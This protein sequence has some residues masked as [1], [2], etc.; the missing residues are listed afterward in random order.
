[1]SNSL[2]ILVRYCQPNVLFTELRVPF[3]LLKIQIEVFAAYDTCL[4]SKGAALLLRLILL[5]G[6]NCL[7]CRLLCVSA[8]GSEIRVSALPPDTLSHCY[9]KVI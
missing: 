9:W 8:S 6:R 5:S 3:V 1:M 2:S 4:V 7:L